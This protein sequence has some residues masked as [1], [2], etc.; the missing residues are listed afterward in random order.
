MSDHGAGEG[1]LAGAEV[2]RQRDQVAR[3]QRGGDVG[4]EALGGL[5]VRQRHRKACTAGCGQQHPPVLV[6]PLPWFGWSTARLRFRESRPLLTK[7]EAV[8]ER[9]IG[10]RFRR[11]RPLTADIMAFI[12]K[13]LR[14]MTLA[15]KIGQLTM[16]NRGGVVHSDNPSDDDL[17]DDLRAG[18]LGSLIGIYGEARDNAAATCRDRGNAAA[19]SADLRVR[20][21][22]RLPDRSSRCRS[23]RR[24]RSIRTCGSAPRAW[25]LAR[26]ALTA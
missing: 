11:K 3:L 19:H 15:E 4:D 21:D 18:R 7:S 23:A 5:L 22:A 24:R 10:T 2:A 26:P 25:P 16:G 8:A 12:E 9:T 13:L 14:D 6:M 17:L 1:G 20:C